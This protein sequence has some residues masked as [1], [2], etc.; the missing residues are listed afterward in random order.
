[1]LASVKQV[2]G[3][4]KHLSFIYLLPTPARSP[5]LCQKTQ[6]RCRRSEVESTRRSLMDAIERNEA[7]QN[8]IAKQGISSH[9]HLVVAHA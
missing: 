6:R 8:K 4:L 5:S 7:K 9:I 3:L 2:P 1:M